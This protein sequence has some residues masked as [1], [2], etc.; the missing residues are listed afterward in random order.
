MTV[1]RVAAEPW[2]ASAADDA[3]KS[4]STVP[5]RYLKIKI[6]AEELGYSVDAVRSLIR[7]GALTTIGECRLLRVTRASID[8][9][10]ARTSSKSIDQ[11]TTGRLQ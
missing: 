7:R 6:A 4:S 11:S 2:Q 8:A 9:Y 3:G 10:L 5:A 1:E